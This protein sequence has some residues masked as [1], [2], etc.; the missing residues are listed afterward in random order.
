M[1]DSLHDLLG[2]AR[3]KREQGRTEGVRG[4]WPHRTLTRFRQQGP[5]KPLGRDRPPPPSGFVRDGKNFA[6]DVSPSRDQSRTEEA[7]NTSVKVVLESQENR[8]TSTSRRHKRNQINEEKRSSLSP[9][10]GFLHGV[11]MQEAS[12]AT[13]L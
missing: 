7:H 4:G 11:W 13:K 5:N 8:E 10:Q 6:Q 2:G 9:P 12:V 1:G 3:A